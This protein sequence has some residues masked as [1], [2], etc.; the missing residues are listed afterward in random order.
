M[1]LAHDFWS[2][3]PDPHGFMLGEYRDRGQAARFDL[4]QSKPAMVDFFLALAF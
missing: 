1:T 4:I 2:N 3:Y